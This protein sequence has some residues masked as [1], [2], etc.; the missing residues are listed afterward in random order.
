[1]IGQDVP[2]YTGKGLVSDASRLR[3]SPDDPD[4]LA[5]VADRLR[6]T[7]AVACVAAGN[8]DVEYA[9]DCAER[10]DVRAAATAMRDAA[11]AQ[12]EFACP[13]KPKPKASPSPKPKPTPVPQASPPPYPT[14]PH[15]DISD[16]VWRERGNK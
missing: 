5:E 4:L 10:G 12:A 2:G 6:A 8:L 11:K 16:R 1:M 9:L 3:K 15:V 7:I 13:F 14:I